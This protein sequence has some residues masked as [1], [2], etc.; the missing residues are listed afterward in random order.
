MITVSMVIMALSTGA[1]G[2]TVAVKAEENVYSFTSPDNGSGP[3]WAYGCT[4][5]LRL[6]DEVIVSEME[7]GKDIPPLC[8]T[9]WRVLRRAADG[10]KVFAEEDGY[11]QREPCSLAAVANDGFFLNVNDSQTPAGTKYQTCKPQLVHFMLADAAAR[12]QIAPKWAGEPTFTDHSY[13]GFAADRARGE[14]LMLNIDAKTSVQN[15]CLLTAAGETVRN[16]SITFPIRSCYPQAAL[17]GGAAYVLAVGDIR[18]PVKEWAD[19]K[20]AQ[21]KQ[22]WDYVFR[23]LHFSSTPDIRA[24]EFAPPIAIANVDA[25]AGALGNQDLWIA[26]DGVAFIL[27]TERE[28]QSALLRDKFFPGKSI[29]GSLYLAVVKDNAIVERRVIIE[30]RQGEE[31]AHARFQQTPD[32]TVYALV[33]MAGANP[34]DVLVQIRPTPETQELAAVPLKV[35]FTSFYLATV[36]A[37]NAPSNTVDVLGNSASGTTIS[38]ACIEIQRGK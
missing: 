26:P 13:R 1:P 18:E 31:P 29:I 23:I 20:Y 36:R 37:G 25:T 4:S 5:I 9:R 15:W 34:R 21:T 19:Y 6:G 35:P 12:Q 11:R 33:F 14:L 3:L 16:G 24:K 28:V 17:E 2:V 38:Y 8:N 7:T 10:W 32:G 30:G 27:Y 22:D